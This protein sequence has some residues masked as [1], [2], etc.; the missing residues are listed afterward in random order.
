MGHVGDILGFQR[1]ALEHLLVRFYDEGVVDDSRYKY[2]PLNFEPAI[3]F[4]LWAKVLY[5]FVL[6]LSLF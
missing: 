4:P 6:L 2:D 1:T 5:P 3:N